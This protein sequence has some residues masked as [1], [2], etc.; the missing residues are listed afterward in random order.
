VGRLKGMKR[1]A[2]I[3]LVFLCLYGHA[4]AASW[5]VD[6]DATG[7]N[8]GTSWANAWTSFSSIKW[9]TSC[10]EGKVCYGDTIYISGG[11]SS[12]TYTAI[13]NGMLTMG[14]GGSDDS[15]RITLSTGAKSPSPSGHDGTVIFDLNNTYHSAIVVANYATLDGEKNGATNW[16]IVNTALSNNY[17]AMSATGTNPIIKYLEIQT[18]RCAIDFSQ[19]TG[20]EIANCNFHDQYG[21][22][23]I[24]G[25]NRNSGGNAWDAVQFHHNIVNINRNPADLSNG[26]DGIQGGPG[27]SIYNNTFMTTTGTTCKGMPGGCQHPDMIQ[28]QGHYMKIYNNTFRNFLDSAIDIDGAGTSEHYWIWNN[29]FTIDSALNVQIPTAI[30]IYSTLGGATA[31]NDILI[32]NNTFVDVRGTSALGIAPA[33]GATLSDIVIKNNI[34]YNCGDYSNAPAVELRNGTGANYGFDYNLVNAGAHGSNNVIINGSSY[35]QAHGKTGTPAFVLYSERSKSNNY[36]LASGDTAAAANGI[37]LG[38]SISTD[39]V[40]NLRSQGPYWSIGAY[41]AGYTTNLNAPSNF[42]KLAN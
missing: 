12:K 13:G 38:Y 18:S 20:G 5:Y 33:A 15:H 2:S 6:K 32:A 21:P 30:R 34:F 31:L 25:N 40:G 11:A 35:T 28:V 41:E 37:N 16:R 1:I 23:V 36:R 9:G 22:A 3:L 27:W 42:R 39:R 14:L 8:N 19:G 4:H 26:A 7:Q 10:P 17:S 24:F 29:I